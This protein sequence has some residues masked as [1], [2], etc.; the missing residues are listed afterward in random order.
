MV[1]GTPDPLPLALR[2]LAAHAGKGVP[3]D[4]VVYAPAEESENF[5]GWGRPVVARWER[6]LIPL[7]CIILM[8]SGQSKRS[9]SSM[10]RSAYD[11]MRI[12]HC[13][14]LRLNTG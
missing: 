9:R 2:A 1:L 3:V 8:G 6:R 10:R 11:V 7:R 14:M 4:V 13:F 12:I 5:D